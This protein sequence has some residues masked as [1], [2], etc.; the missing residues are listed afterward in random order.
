M[1][2]YCL[3]SHPEKCKTCQHLENWETL[4]QMPNALRLSMQAGMK[5]ISI[6][7]CCLTKM[8]AYQPLVT[9]TGDSK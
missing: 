8:G 9:T 5:S 7:A 1:E 3:G 2:Y 4:N 6:N